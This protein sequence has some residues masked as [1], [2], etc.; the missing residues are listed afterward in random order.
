MSHHLSQQEAA[1]GLGSFDPL[2]N[3]L[4]QHFNLPA[5]QLAPSSGFTLSVMDAIHQDAIVPP[6]I[7]FPWKRA[8]FGL[9]TA[10]SAL[11]AFLFYIA[12]NHSLRPAY[13]PRLTGL[14]FSI[15]STQIT[16][17]SILLAVTLSA[18]TL[19]ASFRLAG[20]SR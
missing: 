12:R 9:A 3:Q 8:L 7:P 19:M 16:I 11:L 20:R 4:N 10:I 6:P 14:S 15:N 2:D 5:A 18:A 1:A 17:A 13:V